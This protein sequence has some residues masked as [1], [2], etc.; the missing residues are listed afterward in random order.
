MKNNII[1]PKDEKKI[2]QSYSLTETAIKELQKFKEKHKVKNSSK[3]ID[4]ILKNINK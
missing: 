3:A 4:L 1:I 2:I